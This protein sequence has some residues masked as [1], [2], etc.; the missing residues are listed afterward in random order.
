MVKNM[1]KICAITV[2]YNTT[3]LIKRSI[4]S[5]RKHYPNIEIVVINGSDLTHDC[6][7]YLRSIKNEITL[8]N[9]N[10]NIGHGHGM[11]VAIQMVSRN[12]EQCLIFDSDIELIKGGVIELMQN[13]LNG[14]GVGE[15][16][17]TDDCG[18]N[19]ADGGIR[20]LHPYF[21][22]LDI[23]QY[24]KYPKFVHHGAPCYKAMNCINRANSQHKLKHFDLKPYVKHEHKGTRNLNPK[25]FLQNWE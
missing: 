10:Q 17:I 21:M 11:H 6:T 19:R 4:E 23:N 13:E 24:F 20:Y 25:E 14:Y 18:R 5:I 9:I 7:T 12:Y 22:L 16:V 3:E 8:V 1:K 2:V 15:V